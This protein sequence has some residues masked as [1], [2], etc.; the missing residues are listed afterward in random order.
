M[1]RQDLCILEIH[2]TLIKEMKNFIKI[3]SK[4]PSFKKEINV[5]GDKSILT[6]WV[7]LHQ[8]LLVNQSI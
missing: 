2:L 8:K 3:N 5:P 6:R 7:L 1:I 4:I